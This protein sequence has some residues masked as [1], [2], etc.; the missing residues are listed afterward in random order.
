MTFLQELLIAWTFKSFIL[1]G[2]KRSLILYGCKCD[3]IYASN[4]RPMIFWKY[5]ENLILMLCAHCKFFI[6]SSLDSYDSKLQSGSNFYL[7][8]HSVGGTMHLPYFQLVLLRQLSCRF[9][10]QISCL[11]FKPHILV[12]FRRQLWENSFIEIC[13]W[14]Q[15]IMNFPV[16]QLALKEVIGGKPA[17]SAN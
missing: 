3:V 6:F 17:V 10:N 1:T 13:E 15:Y 7:N 14:T 2:V 16:I 12:T 8:Q 11:F 5:V 4:L 9:F